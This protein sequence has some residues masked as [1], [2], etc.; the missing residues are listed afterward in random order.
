MRH[1]ER[2]NEL[3]DD[4]VVI[5]AELLLNPTKDGRAAFEKAVALLNEHLTDC[6]CERRQYKKDERMRT[7]ALATGIV[8]VAGCALAALFK[9]I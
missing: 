3:E 4:V 8:I 7:I 6:K 9:L 1:N 2:H 5:H